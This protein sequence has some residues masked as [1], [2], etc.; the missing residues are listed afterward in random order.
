MDYAHERSAFGRR[1]I[2]HQGLGFLLADMAAAV[3][4]A[5]AADSGE[6]TGSPEAAGVDAQQDSTGADASA[7]ADAAEQ[8]DEAESTGTE[9]DAEAE[10]EGEAEP[11]PVEELRAAQQAFQERVETELG[12]LR[13]GSGADLEQIR[14]ASAEVAERLAAR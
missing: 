14:A 7:S 4:S 12:Q 9:T 10:T 1:I 6:D 8:A 11:D 3:D 2:D 13:Q 5:R